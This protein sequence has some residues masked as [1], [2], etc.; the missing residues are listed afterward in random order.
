MEL[1]QS[2]KILL[3]LI[4]ISGLNDSFICAIELDE[5]INQCNPSFIDSGGYTCQDY[6]DYEFCTSVGGYGPG[7][8]SNYGDFYKWANEDGE[9]AIICKE[10]GCGYN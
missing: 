1:F 7:W 5:R 9:T 8:K 3:A 2:V 10:C 6:K 4:Y